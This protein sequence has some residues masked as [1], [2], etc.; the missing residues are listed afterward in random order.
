MSAYDDELAARA[1]R[2]RDVA[3][4]RYS[5]IRAA[6]DPGL[7]PRQRGLL[8]RELAAGPHKDPAGQPVSV[9]QRPWTGGSGRGRAA[10]S[11]PWCRAAGRWRRA[12]TRVC[13]SWRWR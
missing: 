6:A 1:A 4:F 10:G 8:V 3:L 12:A 5:V 7:S 2:A 9:G 13:W 11:T